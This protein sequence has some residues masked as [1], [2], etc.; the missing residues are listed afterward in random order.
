[1]SLMKHSV[2]ITALALSCLPAFAGESVDQTKEAA[3]KGLV[4]IMNTRGEVQVSGWDRDEVSVTGELDE[5]TEEFVFEVDGDRTTIEVKIPK[6]NANWGSG[7][8]L[9]IRVPQA[10]RVSFEGVS[11]DAEFEN[12][13]G[14]V[15]ARA[16]SGDITANGIA[17]QVYIK[18][19]S[20]DIEAYASAGNANVTSVSG[21]ITL[22]L[23]SQRL[24]LDNVSGDIRARLKQ[25][26]RLYI[27]IVSGD[28]DV[29]GGLAESGDVEISS[30]S[31]DVDL[32]LN[33]PVNARITVE[34]GP[35]GDISNGLTDDQIKDKFPAMQ[36][37]DTIAGDG[38]G[39]INIRTVTGDIS[40]DSVD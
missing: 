6:R 22:D 16:V 27:N 3:P 30:V 37:L 40:L 36:S 29:E 25:F 39:D 14:G 9:E 11:S 21:E 1:M 38:S 31:G 24:N 19:V 7:S 5:L 18:T 26:E 10:S 32:E 23:D 15:R 35:G 33:A 2:S 28:V 12:I 20:G 17:E 4:D 34:T 13:K 8:D